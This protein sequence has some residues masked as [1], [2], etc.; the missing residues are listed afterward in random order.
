MV[1]HQ[2]RRRRASVPMRALLLCLL[3]LTFGVQAQT[4]AVNPA[5]KD[6]AVIEDQ[7][8]QDINTEQIAEELA[9]K[10]RTLNDRQDVATVATERRLDV[11]EQEMSGNQ[12][13]WIQIITLITGMITAVVAPIIAMQLYKAQ[14]DRKVL[15][16][17]INGVKAELVAE[18]HAAGYF[19][20]VTMAKTTT[21]SPEAIARY[22]ARAKEITDRAYSTTDTANGD[23]A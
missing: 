1:T 21:D 16:N 12:K 2:G 5:I 10:A 7:V 8:R 11:I 4:P 20:G 6:E 9:V 15:T 18:A 3:F 22:D 13:F 19:E 17:S 14:G 23:R